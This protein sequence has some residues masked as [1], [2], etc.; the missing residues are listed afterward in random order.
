VLVAR[1]VS[2]RIDRDEREIHQ[3]RL[4]VL[5]EVAAVVAHELNN[6]L[7]AIMMF[8]QMLASELDPS[9]P[10]QENVAVIERNA[11]TCKQTI[12]ELLDYSTGATPEVGPVDVHAIL[13]DVARF[14]R[15]LCE[16]NETE[17]V[18]QLGEG[19]AVVEGDE[20][21]LRQVFVNLIMNAVQAADGQGRGDAG[22]PPGESGARNGER[23]GRVIVRTSIESGHVL[24]DVRDEGP[25]IR[26]ELA[27][28]VFKPFF[29]TKPRGSGTGLGLPTARR[30]AELQ[31]GGLELVD[32]RP[33]RTTFQ[34]RLLRSA[35]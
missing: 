5:G 30:I 12:R 29:T 3:E 21:Q 1:D 23:G 35:T 10:L 17:L 14:L 18:L 11:L 13:A 6:P 8:N 20:V 2:D 26:P 15:A 28:D 34:V 27:E 24:V 4:A 19:Q 25:G 9:S 31:G 16:R 7:A 33:G 32:G 22:P